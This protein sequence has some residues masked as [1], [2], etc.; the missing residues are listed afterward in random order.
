MPQPQPLQSPSKTITHLQSGGRGDM[1]LLG[2][3]LCV[4]FGFHSM[5]Q[6]VLQTNAAQ[7]WGTTTTTGRHQRVKGGGGGYGGA[8]G[9]DPV[10]ALQE[11]CWSRPRA[12]CPRLAK[13][14]ARLTRQGV[15]KR[16]DGGD[17]PV[18]SSP[19]CFFLKKGGKEQT[20]FSLVWTD[21]M[22][23]LPV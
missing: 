2:V 15:M 8:G 22:S 19:D 17:R 20:C 9:L 12:G 18:V 16:A 1:K 7:Q 5:H 3:I 11:G 14:T 4:A 6:A 23:I 10:F 13:R 21:S